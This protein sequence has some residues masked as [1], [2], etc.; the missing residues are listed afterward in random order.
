MKLILLIT[1][2]ISFNLWAEEDCQA[3]VLDD[4]EAYIQNLQSTEASADSSADE[5]RAVLSCSKK[6]GH[7]YGKLKGG[8]GLEGIDIEGPCADGFIH[9]L[10]ERMQGGGGDM[11]GAFCSQEVQ[12]VIY[13]YLTEGGGDMGGAF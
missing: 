7:S 5:I 10:Y 4:L 12:A 8:E 2:L 3:L 11:G 6:L 9:E 13:K 1:S